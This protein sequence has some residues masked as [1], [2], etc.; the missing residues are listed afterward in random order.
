MARSYAPIVL[1]IWRNDDFLALDA[2]AQ[3]LYLLL[4][5]Q[6]NIDY[7]GV[8]PYMPGRWSKL[9][10]GSTPA[11][12]K[13]AA[14]DLE[15]AKFIVIDTN[16]EELW[17][18][19]FVTH[20][21]VLTQPNVAKAMRSA[22]GHIASLSIRQRFYNSLPLEEQKKLPSPFPPHDP[23]GNGKAE[24]KMEGLQEP[25]PEGLTEPLAP[26]R[27][28]GSSRDL[29]EGFDPNQNQKPQPGTSSST[30]A[31]NEEDA[32]P[33][34]AHIEANRRLTLR[35]PTAPALLSRARWL[36]D[37]ADDVHREYRDQV[38]AWPAM[39]DTEI[40]QRIATG[41]T[42]HRETAAEQAAR[43]FGTGA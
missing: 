6:S 4:I 32:T 35:S 20:N 43:I 41:A 17:V 29:L 7:C 30:Q 24:P 12:I 21:G 1:S 28:L 42:P 39:T 16:T 2:E 34:W 38:T 11:R 10:K 37:V 3:R 25:Q 22:Y 5:S 19:S 33:Q 40:A 8:I 15:E 31:H 13:K 27:G 26:T 23:Q 36:Q 9:A 14:A 18:R